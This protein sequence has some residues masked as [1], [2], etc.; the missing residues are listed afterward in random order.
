MANTGNRLQPEAIRE[1]AFGDITANYVQM[2]ASFSGP[3]RMIYMENTTDVAIYLTVDTSKNQFKLQ[4]GTYRLWDCKTNDGFFNTG[5]SIYVK[6][7]SGLPTSG[8][9]NVEAITA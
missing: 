1:V 6:A 8:E 2:G 4:P 3:I 5:Q 7:V 9:V